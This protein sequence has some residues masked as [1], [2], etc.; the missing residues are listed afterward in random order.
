VWRTGEKYVLRNGGEYW[1]V[2][3]F[4]DEEGYK[5]LQADKT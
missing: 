4:T 5:A 1:F 2:P 3:V